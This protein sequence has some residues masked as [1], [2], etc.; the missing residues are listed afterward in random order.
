M[1]DTMYGLVKAVPAPGAEIQENLPIPSVGSR[2]ILVRIQASAICGT[3]QHIMDWTDY[4][5]KRLTL[6]MVFGHEFSGD[7]VAVGEQ[8]TEVAIGDR[9]AGETHIPCNHCAMCK[10]DQR[11]ICE[12]MKIIGVQA[13]GAF[14]EYISFPVDCAFKL[15]AGFD[16]KV[17][18]L[19]EPMGVAVHGVD[20][21]KV[22]G[23]TVVIN[24]CG[25]IGL[26]AV[27]AAKAWGAKAVIALDVVDAKLDVAREM[28]ADYICNSAASDSISLVHSV[29]G[30]GADV[31]SD[32][33]G[34]I[35]AIRSLFRMIRK[36][37]T[38]VMV[39][40]PNNP[41]QLDLTEDVIYK[42]ATIIGSTGR[43]MYR[44]WEQCVDLISSGAFHI[45]PVIAGTY[46]LRDYEK[47][48]AAIKAGVPGKM[49]LIP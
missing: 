41:I 1:K 6:P 13:P 35:P 23:K 16:Y 42:E 8:V 45:E 40:L 14:S 39:G 5:Q 38:I 32:Y 27:G 17:G 21:A 10:N 46:D 7:V 3:D 48:F 43:L 19:L 24:G 30:A 15:P 9:V 28:G 34:V 2:D 18:A 11:H 33:S 22:A 20:C 26:M 31:A 4:A 37:G 29:T 36:G 25:P 12:N 44:T 49:L 47:A